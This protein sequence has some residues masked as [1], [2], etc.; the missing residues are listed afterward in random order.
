MDKEKVAKLVIDL[1]STKGPYN[2]DS[3][4]EYDV[5]INMGN[6]VTNVDDVVYLQLEETSGV[7]AVHASTYNYFQPIR[8]E[9]DIPQQS[10]YEALA[11]TS[12]YEVVTLNRDPNKSQTQALDNTW[13]W[14]P[15]MW[16]MWR[17]EHKPCRIP[18]RPE[19]FQ[20]KH[21]KIRL[22][23]TGLT[24]SLISQTFTKVIPPAFVFSVSK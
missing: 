1:A 11:D 24:A 4:S 2:S 23:F 9:I 21:W 16:Q 19:V 17:M 15:D 12:T 10:S 8:V 22:L 13:P 5:Q 6:F 14:D 7:T 3:V 20:Q 18:L